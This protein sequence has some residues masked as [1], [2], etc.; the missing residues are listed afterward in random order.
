MRLRARDG[1]TRADYAARM[2]RRE[3]RRLLWLGLL[4]LVLSALIMWMAVRL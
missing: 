2:E 4:L 1:E 3:R